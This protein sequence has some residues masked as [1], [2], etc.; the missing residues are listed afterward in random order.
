MSLSRE[1]LE[2]FSLLKMFLILGKKPLSREPCSGLLGSAA[3]F[4]FCLFSLKVDE[5]AS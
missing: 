1:S 5:K 3:N 2:L 4:F